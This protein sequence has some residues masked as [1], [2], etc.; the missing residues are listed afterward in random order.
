MPFTYP[1][2]PHKTP[3]AYGHGQIEHQALTLVKYAS[4]AAAGLSLLPFVLQIG[5]DPLSPASRAF[6]W[7]VGRCA[8]P[9]ADTLAQH[10]AGFLSPIPLIGV[11]LAAGGLGAIGIAAAVGIGGTLLGRYLEKKDVRFHDI[12][13]GKVVRWAALATTMLFAMPAILSGI[14]MGLHF[15]SVY[16]SESGVNSTL[17]GMANTIGSVGTAGNINSSFGALGLAAT[18]GLICGLPALMTGKLSHSELPHVKINAN[19]A[20]NEGKI[21]EQYPLQFRAA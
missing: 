9:S 13:V 17:S 12:N 6:D 19:S 1:S 2:T 16:L 10:M 15:L 5:A 8:T 14:S 7:A 4:Y 3:E 11:T 18:H 21:W 20:L